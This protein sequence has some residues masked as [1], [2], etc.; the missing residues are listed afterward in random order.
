MIHRYTRALFAD[1]WTDEHKMMI[2]LQVEKANIRALYQRQIISTSTF[3]RLLKVQF[4]LLDIDHYERILKHDVLAFVEACRATL[5]EEKKWFHF[6]LTS[7]DV[8]D[9]AHSLLLKQANIYIQNALESLLSLLKRKAFEYEDVPVMART[10]GMFAEVTSYG[11]RSALWYADLKRL[12]SVFFQACQYVEVCK[13]SGSIGTYPILPPEHE[14]IMAKQLGLMVEPI[15]TQII[16]RDRHATY[17]SALV[18]IAGLLEKIVLDH[19]LLSRSDVNEVAEAFSSEQKGS[20]A[21]PHKRNPIAAENIT[22]LAR[23]MRGYLVPTFEN[24]ALWHERDISH[25]SVERVILM[26]ATTLLDYMLNKTTETL[27]QLIINKTI[28]QEHILAS[29]DVGASQWIL[30]QA[31]L[32]GLDREEVYKILQQASLKTKQ[33]QKSLWEVLKDTELSHKLDLEVVQQTWQPLQHIKT[34]YDRVFN[35]SKTHR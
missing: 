31:I 34:I 22:G 12:Q 33:Q 13:A 19:R 23:L 30:H 35:V 1:L 26:D 16:Q 5:G 15:H 28:M 32:L 29:Y 7:S 14:A 10:H 3:E 17:V 25:S 2:Y 20:S 18:N 4:S 24:Q 9:T 8:I 27:D 21:M 6:G 11:L